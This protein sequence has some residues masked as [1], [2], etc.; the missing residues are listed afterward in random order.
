MS[1]QDIL[2]LSEIFSSVQGEGPSA[3]EP[4]VFLRLALCNLRCGF[5]D[6]RYT[7]DFE[8]YDY[9][10]E[11]STAPVE[12]VLARVLSHSERRLIITGGEPIMQQRALSSLIAQLPSDWQI[13]VET[14][15]T[16]IPNASLLQ[17]VDQWNV[18]PKLAHSEEPLERRMKP[19]V[20]RVL[21]ATQRAYLKLVVRD[22]GD[23]EEV[24]AVVSALEWPKSRV[25]LMPEARTV[26]EHRGRGDHVAELARQL[27]VRYSPRLHVLMFGGER[28]R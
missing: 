25:F 26:P 19:E 23:R 16:L 18:S 14:N 24:E 4:A 8:Q 27:A 3:G 11:V 9:E 12:S 2:K 22:A 20:L 28:G 5:C 17:R 6:T 7:W 21:L 13:E 10:R 15:G 1:A